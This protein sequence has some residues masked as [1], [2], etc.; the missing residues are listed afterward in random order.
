MAKHLLLVSP[1]LYEPTTLA[2][3]SFCIF[4]VK[5]VIKPND[6]ALIKRICCMR[7]RASSNMHICPFECVYNAIAVFA[8]APREI[9]EQ[10]LNV[11]LYKKAAER[12][13]HVLAQCELKYWS[14]ACYCCL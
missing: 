13:R 2:Y 1:S 6:P 8:I 4:F 10:K 11:S 9:I 7:H 5:W 3:Y 14:N 12:N